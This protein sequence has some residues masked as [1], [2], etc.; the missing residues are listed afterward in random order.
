MS[1]SLSRRA[2]LAASANAGRGSLIALTLPMILTAC[3]RATEARLEGARLATL[4]EDEANEFE[5]IAAR[6]IPT[7]DTPGATEAG[8]IYFIDHVVGNGREAEL[9]VLREGLNSLQ[10]TSA[11]TYGEPLFHRLD[12]ASQDRL[13]TDIEDSGFF[14]TLRF[15]TVAGMFALPEYGANEERIGEALIGFENRHVWQ[16]PFGFYDADYIAKGE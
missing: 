1:Q 2:F 6:I 9:A 11:S 10:A 16:P 15:L 7:D 14:Q 5:A 3:S 13:L 4:S 12:A 8:V